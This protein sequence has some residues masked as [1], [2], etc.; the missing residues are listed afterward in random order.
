MFPLWNNKKFVF[1]IKKKKNFRSIYSHI[2]YLAPR[3][4]LKGP[5]LYGKK[6]KGIFWECKGKE[7]FKFN[8]RQK[9]KKK[10]NNSPDENNT[11]TLPPKV[12]SLENL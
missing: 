10:R 11:G 7:K 5:Y 1:Q 3:N 12:F 8:V 4:P 6:R 9:K 2:L